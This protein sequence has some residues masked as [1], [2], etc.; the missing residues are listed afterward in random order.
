MND[1]NQITRQNAE[2]T[3]RDIPVQQAA[4]KFVVAEYA[5]L[6]YVGHQTFDTERE[7]NA[8]AASIA[9]DSNPTGRSQVYRPTTPAEAGAV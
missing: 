6:H 4:G 5:G 2:A 3:Q 1:L 9:T 8:H 7:A